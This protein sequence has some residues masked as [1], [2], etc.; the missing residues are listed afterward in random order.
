MIL[1]TGNIIISLSVINDLDCT[2]QCKN[3]GSFS[4]NVNKQQYHLIVKIM[5][6]N[7]L[8]ASESWH[9]RCSIPDFRTR[10]LLTLLIGM[11]LVILS[12][13]STFYSTALNGRKGTWPLKSAPN[14]SMF[15]LV[16]FSFA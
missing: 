12:F 14:M 11:E 4:H 8:L 13:F 16:M 5:L 6:I 7:H 15:S 2:A 9:K 10:K 3:H 1:H